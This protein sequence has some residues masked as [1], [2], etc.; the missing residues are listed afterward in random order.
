M[1]LALLANLS[2]YDFGYIN[3]HQLLQRTADTL[4]TMMRME[5]YRG[6]FYNSYDTQT[7]EP[8]HPRYVSTVDDGNLAGHLL[9][10]RQ[11]LL[12]LVNEPLL[13][14]V[15]LDGLQDTLD[16]LMENVTSRRW[17]Y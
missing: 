8:L 17:L 14:V 5:R 2:A 13:R 16:V 1:G 15:Y 12:E 9:T 11:G 7:L 4:R 3:H 10:L 6:H